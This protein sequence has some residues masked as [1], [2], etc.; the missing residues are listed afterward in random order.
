MLTAVWI[1]IIAAVA[2]WG[3][4]VC[5]GVFVMLRAARLISQ[6]SGV[7]TG[8]QQR[9]EA[10]MDEADAVTRRA[11]E[12]VTNA[13]AITASMNEVTSSMAELNGRLTE[14]ARPCR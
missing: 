1:A 10:L 7:M 13:E 14:L 2:F 12:Q 9:S 6:T 4:A 5:A 8:L 11:N 3:L